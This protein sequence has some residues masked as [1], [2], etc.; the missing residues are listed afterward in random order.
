MAKQ[1]WTP[2]LGL[3]DLGEARDDLAED[4]LEQ[5]RSGRLWRP[6]ADVMETA[7]EFT[8]QV[9]LPGL[10]R[11]DVTIEVQG[12]ELSIH[13]ERRPEMAVGGAYQVMER[14]YGPFGRTFILPDAAPVDSIRASMRNGLLTVT[15][16]KA[17]PP[18]ARRI[19]VSTGG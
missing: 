11:E 7:E 18:S 17:V 4:A 13:G 14:L 3:G 15:V 19:Q 9:E 6:R 8:I 2:W 16:P 10:E 12:R 5:R 1:H